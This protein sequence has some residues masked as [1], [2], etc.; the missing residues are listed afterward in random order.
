MQLV[1]IGSG[2]AVPQTDRS[3]PCHLIRTEKGTLVVDL[4][5]GSLWGLLRLGHVAPPEIDRVFLSHLHLDHCADLAPLLFALRSR[6]Y[7]RTTPLVLH[8]PRGLGEHYR[9]LRVTW[10]PWVEPREFPL[11]VEEWRGEEVVWRGTRV[12]AAVTKHSV[13]NLAWRFDAADRPGIL[14]TGDGEPTPELFKL[15]ALGDHYLV[16]ECSAGEGQILEGH[17]NP[18]QAGSLARRCG[19]EKLILTHLNP[20]SDP[21]GIVREARDHFEGEVLIAEDGMV[22]EIV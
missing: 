4:G 22:V 13:T 17:M 3:A 1:V 5:P 19:S 16:A 2:T 9:N 21:E 6:E 11:E 7:A 8:G 10:G 15:A 14:V 20:G 18:A 12:R